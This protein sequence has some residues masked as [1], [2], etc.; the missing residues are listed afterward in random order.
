MYSQDKSQNNKN[1]TDAQFFK[2]DEAVRG[3][4]SSG[5]RSKMLTE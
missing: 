4:V 5:D 3:D 1:A 2:H